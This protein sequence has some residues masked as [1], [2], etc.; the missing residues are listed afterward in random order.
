MARLVLAVVMVLVVAAPAAAGPWED[1]VVA[2]NRGDY[3]TALRLWRPLAEQG[4]VK[5]QYKLGTM[6]GAGQGVLR[7]D[8]EAVKWFRRAAE[9][10]EA[11]ENWTFEHDSF[12][13]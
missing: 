6:Y 5:A 2:Y 9:R 3:A 12:M 8:A 7:D 11:D 4:N 10:A 1:A 13:D